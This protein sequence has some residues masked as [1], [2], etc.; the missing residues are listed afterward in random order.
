MLFLPPVKIFLYFHFY[1]LGI[2]A[3]FNNNVRLPF[4]NVK[5]SEQ[6]K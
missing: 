1:R 6:V 4:T 3:L 2:A 5:P